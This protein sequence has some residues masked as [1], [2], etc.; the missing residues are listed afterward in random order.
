MD[1]SIG[2][3]GRRKLAKMAKIGE[4]WQ[5]LAT[6]GENGRKWP[7][8]AI[9]TLTSGHPASKFFPPFFPFDVPFQNGL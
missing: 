1:R 2:F 7:K 8:M 9:I 6:I 3:K 5:K 4:N